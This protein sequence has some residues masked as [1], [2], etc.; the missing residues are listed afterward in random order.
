M[1]AWGS[2][3][4]FDGASYEQALVAMGAEGQTGFVLLA[5]ARLIFCAYASSEMPFQGFREDG[6]IAEDVLDHGVRLVEVARSADLKQMLQQM[7]DTSA[8]LGDMRIQPLIYAM[9]WNVQH[10][11]TLAGGRENEARILA[12]VE[13]CARMVDVD[14][15]IAAE[16]ITF[17]LACLSQG[18]FA[19]ARQ[20]LGALADATPLPLVMTTLI[21]IAS[22]IMTNP[23]PQLIVDEHGVPLSVAGRGDPG[24]SHEN[25]LLRMAT[26][27]IRAVQAGDNGR[28][29]ELASY[30]GTH[31][32]GEQ[33]QLVWQLA[34]SLGYK[35]A[36]LD[37][38]A[39]DV[40]GH[41]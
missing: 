27:G 23:G 9:A 21:A 31:S 2:D 24:T 12:L 16:P 40:K 30:V 32:I 5:W 28:V 38:P 13:P 8:E 10:L 7:Q 17:A 37:R 6:T 19:P 15:V 41:R 3:G 22:R 35:L 36:S 39:T 11:L 4:E 20:A 33:A 25:R 29:R 34:V 18:H 14:A 26:E 1:A